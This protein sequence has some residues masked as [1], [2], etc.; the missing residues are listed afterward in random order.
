LDR[1]EAEIRN[2]VGILA[3]LILVRILR[4]YR[5][6]AGFTIEQLAELLLV[7]PSKI[8]R[9]ETGRAVPTTRDIRDF[10]RLYELS[11]EAESNLTTLHRTASS[12]SSREQA[13]D[14]SLYIA[15]V[16]IS[17]EILTYR[18]HGIPSILWSPRFGRAVRAGFN[19]EGEMLRL[20]LTRRMPPD[21][22]VIID[23]LALSTWPDAVA[24]D[25]L[26]LAEQLD[27]VLELARL[28]NV[29]L[30]V[31]PKAVGGLPFE[32]EETY[33]LLA[34]TKEIAGSPGGTLVWRDAS[35]NPYLWRIG[36]VYRYDPIV[37]KTLSATESLLIIRDAAQKVSAKVRLPPG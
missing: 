8:S 12:A 28:P 5:E 37:E 19:Q 7:S 11:T 16:G 15:S 14:F 32:S 27:Y 24:V 34:D 2:Y 10:G 29:T 22:T 21:L 26:L 1:E 9:L 33:C 18:A 20:I 4:K 6:D 35:T 36:D 17:S 3:R 23:E 30:L 13:N 25:H 31:L